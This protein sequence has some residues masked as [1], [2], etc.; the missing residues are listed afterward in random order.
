MTTTP[1][2]HTPNGF[3]GN[4]FFEPLL[5]QFF[6]YQLKQLSQNVNDPNVTFVDELFGRMGDTVRLQVK[7][8]LATHPGWNIDINFPREDAKLPL[9][10][11][12]TAQ[13]DELTS[14]TYL[15]DDGGVMLMGE[16]DVQSSSQLS[17]GTN[18]YGQRIAAVDERPRATQA[19]FLLSVPQSHM[20]RIYIATEDVNET[21]Y[22]YIILKALLLVNKLDFDKYCGA[23]N[24]KLS[25]SDFEHKQ[26]MFPQFAFAKILTIAYEM[27]FDVALSPVKTIGGVDIS[28]TSF[29]GS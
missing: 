16:H 11:I 28:L 1:T 12:V 23:R 15:G 29:F 25:G 27:N 17:V 24:M 8:W 19:R 4:M 13:D 22:L 6:A 7:T 10:A 26:E 2:T 18:V 3:T 9:I 20:T 14:G 21:L 5:R